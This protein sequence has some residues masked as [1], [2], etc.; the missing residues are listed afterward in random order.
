[1]GQ[2]YVGLPMALRAAETGIEVI[3]FDTN[4]VVAEA[5]VAGRSHIGDIS[6][7]DLA[8]GLIAGYTATA[9]PQCLSE[10]DV[11][12]VC[13]PTPLG[14]DGGPDLGA[15]RGAASMIGARVR[16]GTLCILESTTYPG[17]TEEVFAPRV[18]SDRL[19]VGESVFVAFSP[20]RINPGQTAY[21]VKNTPKVVGG[22]TP[23]CT[24]RAAEF[25]GQFVDTVVSA[26][27]A[28]EAE[29]AKLLE[30]TFRHVNIALVNEMV[31][32]SHE[33]DIDLWNAIDCAETKPF[34]FMA[35]RPGPGVGGHC[36][37]V[38]PSYLSH[39]VKAML[40]Y[41]FRMVELAE[42][43][44][45]AAPQYVVD[46]VAGQL[47]DRRQSMKGARILLLGVTYKPNVA[48]LR[49]TPAQPIAARLLKLG[50]DVQFHDPLVSTWNVG[51]VVL[52]SVPDPYTAAAAA[53]LV[54]LLQPHAA[55]DFARLVG[56][57]A[58]VFDSCGA[59]RPAANVVRL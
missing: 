40:G 28:K 59:L 7:A 26:K 35:F 18:C 50:A 55:Y 53:D 11:I 37:P 57:G 36:I 38:D 13:V 46:R 49:E 42:E 20:E 1:M 17:T 56:T 27:G 39:R 51:D 19:K 52:E 43:V 3:G 45:A 9:D 6:D 29:M 5:L 15:V 24:R 12:I 8:R 31:R 4:P 58:Q 23:E 34:G 10:A 16:P 33:L 25:Y 54:V 44:N 2:G 21:L 30:N 48:D 22:L 14:E 47:N 41:S 32:F